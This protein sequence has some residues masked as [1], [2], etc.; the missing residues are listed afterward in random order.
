LE[1]KEKILKFYVD[2]IETLCYS[3]YAFKITCSGLQEL[4]RIERK[5]TTLKIDRQTVNDMVGRFDDEI[6]FNNYGTR[7]KRGVFDFVGQIAKILFGTLDSSDADYYNKQIDL[8][9]NNSKQLTNLY[10]KT[11]KHYAFDN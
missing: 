6:N 5:L 7:I 2:K 8:V 10:K 3:L 1:E 11:D 9:Y 4:Q